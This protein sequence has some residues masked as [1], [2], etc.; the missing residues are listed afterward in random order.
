[1]AI[2]RFFSTPKGLLL[3][4]LVFLVVIAAR[5]EGVSVVAPGLTGAV[6][7]AGVI[8]GLIL[9]RRRTAWTFPD[10]AIL[11]GLLVA[12]LLSPH[13]PVYVFAAASSLAIVS[14]YAVRSR[15]ANVFNPAALAL[16]AVFY[17]FGASQNWWGALAELPPAGL[18]LLFATGV[19]ITARVN[20]I[21]MVLVF[22]GLY[23]LLFTFTAFIGNAERVAEIFRAPDLHAALFFAF[24]ILTDPPTSPVRYSDQML[25]GALV[26][27]SSYLFFEA[28]GAVYYLL[29]GVLI[30]NLWEAWRRWR[31]S[32]RRRQAPVPAS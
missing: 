1:L 16:V 10:G 4:I 17:L 11:T 30:G 5:G 18:V 3:I 26:A 15:W 23:Y 14:K 27:L 13:Q 8:D 28:I 25:C 29:A 20:K 12:M 32:L 21:P 9:W 31:A 2:R 7:S 22:L 24:F 19:F 6:L